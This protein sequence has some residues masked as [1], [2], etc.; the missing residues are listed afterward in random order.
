MQKKEAEKHS[1]MNRFIT[2]Y[3]MDAVKS[4]FPLKAYF[5]TKLNDIRSEPCQS[6]SSFA[7]R[8]HIKT[9]TWFTS[10]RESIVELT[11]NK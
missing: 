8:N 3:K 10:S 6:D 1:K 2:T 9:V 11:V 7:R 5:R 4:C